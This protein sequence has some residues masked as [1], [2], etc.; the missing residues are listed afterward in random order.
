MVARHFSA[1][2]YLARRRSQIKLDLAIWIYHVTF[3]IDH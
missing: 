3:V 2:H 1:T